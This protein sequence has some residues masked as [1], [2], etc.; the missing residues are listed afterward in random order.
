MFHAMVGIELPGKVVCHVVGIR[1][2]GAGICG[3]FV[4]LTSEIVMVAQ[5]RGADKSLYRIA[6][7]CCECRCRNKHIGGVA[8]N[9]T[10]QVV[11]CAAQFR[12]YF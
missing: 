11:R 10:A 6:A 9:E 2:S 7:D 4:F 5:F 8:E 12:E 3:V 1:Q